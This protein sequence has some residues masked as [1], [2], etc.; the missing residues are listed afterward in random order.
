MKHH[1]RN[2]T[3]ERFGKARRGDPD[4]RHAL[5][6]GIG[7][8]ASIRSTRSMQPDNHKT[9]NPASALDGGIPSRFHVGP[10][11]PAA[12]DVQSSMR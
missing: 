3:G 12:S 4:E 10:Q 1:Q 2:Q 6:S 8:R 9:P 11:W 7:R 5:A